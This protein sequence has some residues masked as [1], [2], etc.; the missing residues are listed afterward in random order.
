[1]RIDPFNSSAGQISNEPGSQQ[2]SAQN[3]AKSGQTAAEDRATL[4]SDSTSV[5]SLVSTALSSPDVRQDKVASLQQSIG[6][7]QYVLDPVKIAASM[8]DEHA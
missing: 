1:M 6:S 7:G 8:I 4:T 3:T 2:V 5:G